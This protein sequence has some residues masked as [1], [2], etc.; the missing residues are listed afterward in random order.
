MKQSRLAEQDLPSDGG[1]AILAEYSRL[2]HRPAENQQEAGSSRQEAGLADIP[3]SR[4]GQIEELVK[5][6]IVG[7]LPHNRRIRENMRE[8]MM[9]A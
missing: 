2:Y 9:T 3:D 4:Q 5:D 1:D 7:G 8:N 6:L